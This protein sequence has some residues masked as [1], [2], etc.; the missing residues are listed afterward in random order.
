MALDIQAILSTASTIIREFE[1]YRSSAYRDMAG[2]WTIGYGFTYWSGHKVTASYPG[3]PVTI[4]QCNQQ[5]RSVLI[6]LLSRIQTS[7]KVT[8]SD[9]QYAALLCFSYNVG[10]TAFSNSTMLRLINEGDIAQ[11][12]EQ[13]PLWDKSGGK[14][15]PGLLK[16]RLA[17]QKLFSE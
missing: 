9:T 2:V 10:Y 15:V 7:V 16:R 1:G 14:V 4:T 3:F 11:A 13:F 5:L 12:A 17:E 8:L 6:P